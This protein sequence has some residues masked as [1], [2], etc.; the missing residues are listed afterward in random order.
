MTVL[1]LAAD[2]PMKAKLIALAFEDCKMS[3]L[4]VTPEEH[5]MAL[6][7][8]N[9]MMTE[10]PFSR[11]PYAHP[12]PNVDGEANEPSGIPS[13][14]ANGVAKCLAMVL[15]GVFG[16]D[17]SR[18]FTIAHS[19]S[20]LLI[21]AMYPPNSAIASYAPGTI[22]GAGARHDG[23]HSTPFFPLGTEETEVDTS[24]DPGDLAAIAS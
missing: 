20:K 17:P 24:G 2:G 7:K 8:L 4:T 3:D 23:L 9:A 13:K 10:E 15:H 12:L 21:E 16:I 11:I 18:A 1:P 5:S 19:K 14:A 6:R 22:R